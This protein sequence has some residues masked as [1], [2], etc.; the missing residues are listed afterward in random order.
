MLLHLNNEVS[1]NPSDPNIYPLSDTIG[2]QYTLQPGNTTFSSLTN[3]GVN[4]NYSAKPIDKV[5]V[6]DLNGTISSG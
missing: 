5:T 6:L 2:T 4:S 1:Y 3:V